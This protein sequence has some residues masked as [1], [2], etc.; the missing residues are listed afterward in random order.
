MKKMM[1]G[2]A[3][4]AVLLSGCQTLDTAL[5]KTGSVLDATGDILSG[6]LRGLGAARQA[7]LTEIW[8]DWQQNEVTAKRKWDA[9]RITVPGV[10]TRITKTDSIGFQNQ[11]AV[12]FRDPTNSKCSGQGLTR[13]DLKVNADK[14]S[15]LKAGDKVTVTGVL[16][17]SASKWSDQGSCWFSFDKAEIVKTSK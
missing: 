10:I 9:Q 12:I 5:A 7:T 11:I 4:T 15:N 16:G 3:I 17:T 13:D 1:L 14:I 2:L 8:N 6:D